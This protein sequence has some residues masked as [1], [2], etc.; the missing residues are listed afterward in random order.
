MLSNYGWIYAFP[1]LSVSP[2]SAFELTIKHSKIAEK[3][4]RLCYQISVKVSGS[5]LLVS[6]VELRQQ[7]SSSGSHLWMSSSRLFTS[8][9]KQSI[10]L[11]SISLALSLLPVRLATAARNRHRNTSTAATFS[12]STT[13]NPKIMF[14][15]PTR[16]GEFGWQ[17]SLEL[18]H[19]SLGFI[20]HWCGGVLINKFWLLTSAHCIHKW[21]IIAFGYR[22]DVHSS[23]HLPAICST[24]R[25]RRC[26][27]SCWEKT[28]V[29]WS[30]ATS[31]GYQWIKSSCTRNTDTSR[32][33]W[34]S[35]A[36]WRIISEPKTFCHSSA[37]ETHTTR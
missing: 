11:R 31:S 16:D 12:T 1:S 26:G 24:C 4:K 28:T 19:P 6:E 27:R 7:W 36:T 5:C 20:G 32:M 23:S 22:P 9:I 37:Y 25:Y 29:K 17:A 21:V 8:L 15:F 14:G 18:L 34:V 13:R 30:R 33:I 10:W 35:T 2:C 3:E